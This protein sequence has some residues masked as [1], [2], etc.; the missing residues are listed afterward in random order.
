[1]Y[2]LRLVS[3]TNPRSHNFHLISDLLDHLE[4]TESELLSHCSEVEPLE[5]SVAEV[6]HQVESSKGFYQLPDS[7]TAMPHGRRLRFL[8]LCSQLRQLLGIEVEN[9]DD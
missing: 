1:M 8:P 7:I 9:L 2:N 6:M 5:M 3:G 4:C